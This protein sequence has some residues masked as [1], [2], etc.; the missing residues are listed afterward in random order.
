MSVKRTNLI[1]SGESRRKLSF[2]CSDVESVESKPVFPSNM[3]KAKIYYIALDD[4]WRKEKKLEWIRENHI[5]TIAFELIEPDAKNNWIN[6]TDN[7]WDSLLPLIDKEVKAGKSEEAV[8]KLFSYGFDTKR[9]DYVYS[10][11]KTELKLKVF[12]F[13]DEYNKFVK[14]NDYAQRYSIKWSRNLERDAKRNIL[15][16]FDEKQIVT[17]EYRPYVKKYLYFDKHLI[18]ENFQW[19]NI[20][21]KTNDNFYIALSGIS[22]TKPFQCFSVNMPHCGDLLEKTQSLPLYTFDSENQKHENITDWGLTQFQNHYGE[23]ANA[24]A[25]TTVRAFDAENNQS[26]AQKSTLTNVR[27]SASENGAKITKQDIFYY[28]Y[29]VLHSPVYRKKYEQNLKREFPRLPFYEDFF[30]WRDWGKELMNLHIN[31]ETQESF[32][33]ERKDLDLSAKR[34]IASNTMFD[35]MINARIDDFVSK[36]QTKLRADKENGAILLDSITT[37]TG[38]PHSAWEYKLGNRS[39]LE[40]ILD[41]YKERKPQDA[42]IAERFNT[43]KFEDYKEQV[44]DLLKRVCNVSVKTMEIIEKMPNE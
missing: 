21:Q 15:L 5:S 36:P 11:D 33:L 23:N 7:D 37:L 34:K 44:I 22:H 6:Q 43:Y 2:K 29:A 31:Y 30:R 3:S 41:Q 9:D 16:K 14:D 19:I 26:E 8:F 13:I 24:E 10:F 35:E 39:A 40:W 38:V 28:T 42:T 18:S 17:S 12:Y 25:R 27:V 1:A 20:N 4:F 32:A